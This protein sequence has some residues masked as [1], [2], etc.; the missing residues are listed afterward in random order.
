MAWELFVPHA[1]IDAFLKP[2]SPYIFTA[3]HYHQ[4][5]NLSPD[6]DDITSKAG[7]ARRFPVFVKM[8]VAALQQ[9]SGSTSVDLLEPADLE[10]LRSKRGASP[11][12]SQVRLPQNKCY[13]ILSCVGEFEKVHYPLPLTLCVDE[14]PVRLR[15]M[16]KRLRTQLA[17]RPAEPIFY[18]QVLDLSWLYCHDPPTLLGHTA[19]A[20]S[21]GGNTV[22]CAIAG[23]SFQQHWQMSGLVI[24]QYNSWH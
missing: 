12:Q 5:A 9:Q 19:R 17:E 24:V 7:S 3:Q 11:A 10:A 1:S 22:A 23:C 15:E 18:D 20:A 16:I 8:L 14:E 13:L 4:G 2:I 6:V 21:K